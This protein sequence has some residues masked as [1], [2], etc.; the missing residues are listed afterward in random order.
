MSTSSSSMVAVDFQLSSEF[1][2]VREQLLSRELNGHWE[3]PLAYW[4]QTTD[5]HLPMALVD[6]TLRYVVETPFKQLSRTPG[7][8]AKKLGSLIMLMSRAAESCA[9]PEG[10]AHVKVSETD[11]AAGD[12]E[13]VSEAL[14]S[15]WASSLR[16]RGLAQEMLGRFAPSLRGLPRLMWH[17][18][19]DDYLSLSLDE[20]HALRGHGHK[21]V[22][23]LIQIVGGLH[24]I[25]ERL[26]D[27]PHVAIRI[28]PRLEAQLEDWFARCLR[29]D[30][31]SSP[32]GSASVPRRKPP[33]DSS[34]CA[35]L[36]EPLMEQARIDLGDHASAVLR[37][38]LFKPRSSMQQTA[39]QVGLTRGRVYELLADAGLVLDIRWP[40][41]RRRMLELRSELAEAVEAG[42]GRPYQDGL[43]RVEVTIALLFRDRRPG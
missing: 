14:W 2:A 36:L 33:D 11:D 4:A 38:R 19:L 5:R 34:V 17:K 9:S 30:P 25:T 16:N 21:R 24:R 12:S 23:I 40:Q 3:K 10:T 8:G 7:I 13:A 43:S 6:K 18:R 22:A 28:G 1:N 35:N 31:E 27:Q 20:I 41:G 39:H 42:A 26:G 15:K 37:H 29:D 32:R